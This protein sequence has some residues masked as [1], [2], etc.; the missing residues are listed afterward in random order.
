MKPREHP[1]R[2]ASRAMLEP[3]G[4]VALALLIGWTAPA[5]G[6]DAPNTASTGPAAT[7]PAPAA[8]AAA[9]PEAATG[10][11]A[12]ARGQPYASRYLAVTANGHA[13]EA[14]RAMLARGGS[15]TDAAIAA[16][17]V[18]NLVEPQ[19]SGIGGGGF[20][21]VLD[22]ARGELLAYD[23]RE[24]APRSVSGDLFLDAQGEPIRFFDAV[25]G[26]RAVGTPGLMRMLE[27]AHARHGRLAWSALFEPAI[28]LA[29][30]GF[31][32]G[33]RLH[34]LLAAD[35]FLRRDAQAASYFYDEQGA[36][37]AIG[38]RLRNPALA[39]TLATLA[40]EGAAALYR[41]PLARA[42]VDKVR[43]HDSNPGLLT[44]DDLA[45]YR[46]KARDPVCAPYLRFLVCGMPAP[47]SGGI[48][49]AQILM[50]L[51]QAG[52]PALVGAD[53]TLEPAGVHYFA[54]AGRLAYAD[55]NRYLAD[56][57]FAT[58]P[59]GILDPTYVGSRALLIDADR[60]MQRAEPGQP[61][62][63]LAVA[64]GRHYPEAGTTHLSIVDAEGNAVAL[65][66]SIENAFGARQMVA[67]FLLN[68]Q[69]TDFSFVPAGPGGAVANRVGPGKRPRSSMAPTMVFERAADGS[70]GPL[71]MVLGSPGGSR[72]IN[73]VAQ[74][75]V[76]TLR[77]GLDLQRAVALPHVGSRNGP[78]ELEDVPRQAPTPS[79]PDASG[80]PS[81][82]DAGAGAGSAGTASAG[83]V[84]AGTVNTAASEPVTDIAALARALE[85]RGH[86]PRLTTM[87]SGLHAILVE[88]SRAAPPDPGTMR[89]W[90][91]VDPRR[92][93]VALGD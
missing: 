3:L 82:T 60:S 19:S 78:T 85:A 10:R 86:Q 28:R 39:D 53:G 81:G 31:A 74:V 7:Q 11:T 77:D 89:L 37:H 13:T 48:T 38:H 42:I 16:Q 18:L 64:D 84:S 58:I 8:S 5:T 52:A 29:R 72:I 67:G 22:R 65:T 87:T 91:G 49:V 21:L 71:T 45:E 33:P 15:A 66:S 92:E 41:G 69:L 14:A 51:E 61:P 76:S 83:T 17:M 24:T 4:W 34:A 68:N 80:P 40:R 56:P 57:D 90:A 73:Y 12:I 9:E 62:P 47:S 2:T 1:T 43:G 59:H 30:D 75:L 55:R 44:L 32:V 88:R 46:A 54:E 36:P 63:R 35:R 50:L 70:R 26:G 93:G 27:L 25:V 6:R 79:A 23:G 20:M